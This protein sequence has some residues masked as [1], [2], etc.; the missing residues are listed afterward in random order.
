MGKANRLRRQLKEKQLQEKLQEKQ[1]QRARSAAA[2]PLPPDAERSVFEPRRSPRPSP[3]EVVSALVS[4]ASHAYFHGERDEFDAAVS[5]LVDVPDVDGWR[6]LVERSLTGYLKSSISHLWKNGWQ[7][8][9]LVRSVGRS[10]GARHGRMLADAIAAELQA[11]A[12]ATLD[13]RWSSQLAEAEVV[14]WWSPDQSYLRAWCER[15]KNDWVTVM[16]TALEVL[17]ALSG[18]PQIER[19]GP[20]PGTASPPST[21]AK[22]TEPVDERMLSR[23]RALLAK[24]EATTSE[25]E[26]EAFT[27]GAQER[28]ARH[29]IDLAMLAATEPNNKDQPSGRRI[30]IDNPYESS[31]ATLLDA[32]AMANRCRA[33]WSQNLGFCTVIGFEPDLDAVEILFT[34]LLVQA[35]TAMTRAGSRK[36]AG[37][38]SRTRAFRQ[39]FLMAYAARIRERLTEVIEVQTEARVAEPGGA[40]L[41][42]VLASRNHAVDEAR[43]EMFPNLT[44]RSSARISDVEGWHS[45]RGAADLA[46]LHPGQALPK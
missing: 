46:S 23:I 18:L 34:S 27:A 11:Y 33:V 37:G 35:I 12:P 16:S 15:P 19:L 20:V 2:R 9:D 1:R 13:P 38:R 6:G 29:S 14:V 26:A 32:V 7:P 4:R 44:Q 39:S 3:Q 40:N 17:C 22:R 36:D 8:A 25:A 28:M 5:A 31:K 41:L 45:G 42:P 24:A 43:D 30:G 10:F 21:A